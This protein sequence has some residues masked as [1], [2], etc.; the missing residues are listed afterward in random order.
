MELSFFSSSSYLAIRKHPSVVPT[1]PCPCTPAD[2]VLPCKDTR[3]HLLAHVNA[4]FTTQCCLLLETGLH[5]PQVEGWLTPKHGG[6]ARSCLETPEKARGEQT[7]PS[8][9]T[10]LYN[11]C[12]DYFGGKGS[13]FSSQQ[14]SLALLTWPCVY[15]QRSVNNDSGE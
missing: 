15:F 6:Q 13:V 11:Y 3:L 8:C 12:M 10:R 5:D 9:F 1:L 4:F 14:V 2:Q 7:W